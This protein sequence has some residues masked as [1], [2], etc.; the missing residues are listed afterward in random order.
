LSALRRLLLRQLAGGFSSLHVMPVLFTTMLVVVWFQS[1]SQESVDAGGVFVLSVVP[2]QM[3]LGMVGGF[4]LRWWPYL[5][6]ESLRP[7]G[8]R[9][10][11][12]GLAI[13]RACDTAAAAGMHC[14]MPV[15]LLGFFSPQ[16]PHGLL[17]RRVVLTMAQ[18][19]AGYCVMYWL[20]SFRR[21][22]VLVLG[23]SGASFVSAALVTA[24]LF[25]NGGFWPPGSLALAILATALAVAWF[26]RL[27]FRRWCRI[28]LD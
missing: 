9:D 19:V 27:T 22:W 23:I 5:A 7:L 20:V 2:M 10:F 8:R 17:L 21:F 28:D 25:T 24:A 3:T 1:W 14:A 13:S 15:V 12:R 4:W 26:Y 11:V 16:G 18:Y 6:H